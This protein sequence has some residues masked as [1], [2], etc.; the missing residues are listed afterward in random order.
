VKTFAVCG[1]NVDDG[2]RHIAEGDTIFL[3]RRRFGELARENL[4]TSA[5]AGDIR[6]LSY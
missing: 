6:D 3:S 4:L 1:P 2:G 5:T